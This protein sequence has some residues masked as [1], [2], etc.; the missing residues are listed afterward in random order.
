MSEPEEIPSPESQPQEIRPVR[1]QKKIAKPIHDL[2]E[3]DFLSRR[4]VVRNI[5][6]VFFLALVALVYISNTYYAEKTYKEI[7][8]AKSE[9][10]ELRYQYITVKSN[11]MF[12]STEVEISR[13]ASKL[14]LKAT[15]VPPYKIYY[16][17]DSIPGN[18]E[19]E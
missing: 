12:E 19:G 9:L 7:E 4:M 15:L 5:P 16:S 18:K 11:L 2:L 14:G 8:Q 1:K 6:F 17:S 10:K 3:G 13:R